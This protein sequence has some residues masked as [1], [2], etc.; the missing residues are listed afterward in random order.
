MDNTIKLNQLEVGNTGLVTNLLNSGISRRRMLDLGIVPNSKI[1][2]ER[3]SPS[4]N[5]IAYNIK[6]SVIALRNEE[7]KY[8]VVKVIN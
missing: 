5:P 8:I 4:G 3:R 1:T 7:A 6:G 2:V